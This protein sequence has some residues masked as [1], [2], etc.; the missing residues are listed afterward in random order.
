MNTAL[1]IFQKVFVLYSC[2]E[3]VDSLLIRKFKRFCIY[4]YIEFIVNVA[5]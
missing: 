2:I 1:S 5:L 4:I 3:E